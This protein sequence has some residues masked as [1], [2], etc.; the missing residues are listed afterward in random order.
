MRPVISMADLS[1]EPLKRVAMWY[2]KDPTTL[3]TAPSPSIDL[4]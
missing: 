2:S 1:S 4:A 3:S